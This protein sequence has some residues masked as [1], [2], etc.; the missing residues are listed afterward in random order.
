MV[1]DMPPTCTS[2]SMTTGCTSERCNSSY[3]AVRDR[4]S[5]RLNSSHSQISY[6][7]FCLKKKKTTHTHAGTTLEYPRP[8]PV[9]AEHQTVVRKR[10]VPWLDRLSACVVSSIHPNPSSTLSLQAA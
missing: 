8:H 1:F 2:A 5:T 10:I 6:A 7:V 9:F 3:A 4:K